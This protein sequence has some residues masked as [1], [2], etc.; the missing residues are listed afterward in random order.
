[1][2]FAKSLLLGVSLAGLVAASP[3][4]AGGGNVKVVR[5]ALHA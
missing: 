3:A 4:M 1:M 2:H 5:H